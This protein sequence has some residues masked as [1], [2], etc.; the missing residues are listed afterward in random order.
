MDE[1]P[2]DE[3]H[4][5]LGFDPGK[6]RSGMIATFTNVIVDMLVKQEYEGIE[7]WTKGRQL[8]ASEIERAVEGF[9]Q[10]LIKVRVKDV[11]EAKRARH[12]DRTTYDVSVPMWTAEGR[13]DLIV[14]LRFV[15]FDDGESS[16][17]LLRFH[18]VRRGRDPDAPVLQTEPLPENLP[19]PEPRRLPPPYEHPVPERWR[20]L[21]AEIVHRLV[22]K[23][24]AGL[25]RDGFVAYTSDPSD[26]SIGRWIEDYPWNLVDLPDRAWDFSDHSSVEDE[27][28]WYVRLDLW[29]AEEGLSDLSLEATVRDDGSQI[30]VMIGNVH[31]M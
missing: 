31:V 22:I 20:P 9:G 19:P 29:T 26:E 27:D 28:T 11:P 7:A 30:S 25:S 6:Y 17:E 8:N 14:E 2:T 24:Y 5:R 15:E 21:L 3:F 1:T 4:R 12:S 18:Q 10:R 23:D 16:T 13:S